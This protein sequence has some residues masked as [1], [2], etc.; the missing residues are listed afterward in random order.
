MKIQSDVQ[1][2]KQHSWTKYW[3]SNWSFLS[4]WLWG[5]YYTKLMDQYIGIG[6]KE[7]VII[8]RQ[9]YS[10]CFFTLEDRKAYGDFLVAK[11]MNDPQ[12][13]PE[14]CVMLKNKVDEFRVFLK[15]TSEPIDEKHFRRYLELLY[16][17][18]CWHISPRHIIDY[19]PPTETKKYLSQLEEVRIYTEPVFKET[20]EFMVRYAKEIERKTKYPA[21]LICCLTGEELED[22]WKNNN[23]PELSILSKRLPESAIIFNDKKIPQSVI[24]GKDVIEIESALFGEVSVTEVKGTIAY[25]GKVMGKVHIVSDPKIVSNFIEGEILV[26]G[27]TRP[28]FLPLMKKA[29]AFVTDSGGILCHAAI[30]AREMHKPGII[31]TEKATKVFKDGDLVEVDA[32]KGIVRKV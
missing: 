1:F 26:T 27:M 30:T 11:I 21:E 18:T 13:L 12:W 6:F 19:L 29:A 16:S 23:L 8:A 24:I 3:S 28:D 4:A 5:N 20:E 14:F 22:Y 15:D 9:G 2:I 7:T 17:Y 31:G 25:P 10:T 32:E